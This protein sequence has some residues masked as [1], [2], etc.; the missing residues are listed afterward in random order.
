MFNIFKRE[1]KEK[2]RSPRSTEFRV[3]FFLALRDIRRASVWTT[4]LIITV[5]MLTFLNLVV[6][7]G[8]L[9]GLIEGTVEAVQER[10]LGDVFVS[11]LKNH[12]YIENTPD[13]ATYI[14]TLPQVEAV[15]V[16]YVENGRIESNYKELKKAKEIK[17]YVSTS[18][19]GIVPSEEEKISHISE[20]VVEG[21]FLSDDDYDKVVLGASL[22]RKYLDIDSSMFSVLGLDVGVGSKIRLVV[23]GNTRDVIIKGIVRTKVDE[24]DRR[25]FFTSSQFRALI[26]RYDYSANEM[27]ISLKSKSDPAIVRDA[28]LNAGF[29][30]YAKIQTA[31]DAEPKFVKDLK[32][33]FAILGNIISSIGLVVAAIT[34]FIVIFINAITRRKFIGILKGIGITNFSIELS[35]IIQSVFYAVCGMILGAIITFVILKPFFGAHPIDYP[36]GDGI[37]VATVLGTSIRGLILFIATIIAGYIPARIVINQNTLDAILGR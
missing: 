6:V 20:K 33:T 16:R 21:S 37:L 9:V 23:N 15:T 1:K 27:A 35:Y 13:I 10:Y 19:A 3:G 32:D 8:I 18:F 34:V 5:M 14:K 12:L 30:K 24:I 36:F 2:S 31:S 7:S 29:G 11:T 25:V 26:N 4:L 17:E 22:F 28:L